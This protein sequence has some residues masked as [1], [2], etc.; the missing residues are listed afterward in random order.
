MDI[1]LYI[2]ASITIYVYKI[3]KIKM[4][5][6]QKIYNFSTDGHD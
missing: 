2:S 1:K 4:T 6:Y 3:K 5:I